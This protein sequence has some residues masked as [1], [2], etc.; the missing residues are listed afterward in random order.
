MVM[1]DMEM[2]C[3]LLVIGGGPG[4][5]GAALR[6]AELGLDVALVDSGP[7][8]GG[9]YLRSAC[10]PSK[11]L[12]D[13][14]RLL[15]QTAEAASLGVV[16]PPPKLDFSEVCLA[17]SG[18]IAVEG[19]KL[20]LR[21][22]KQGVLL[23]RGTA[24]F[25]EPRRVRLD[26]AEINRLSFD[27]AIIAVGSSPRLLPGA[28]IGGPVL[29]IPAL[30]AAGAFPPSITVVGGGYIGIELATILA[31]FGSR[32][33]LLEKQPRLLSKAD[34]DL[35]APLVDSLTRR[36]AAIRVDCQ[37]TEITSLDDGVT[38]HCR[39]GGED[40]QWRDGAVLA[41]IG[42]RPAADDL[43]L[44]R[45]LITTD[46]RGYII[47]NERQQTND[48]AIFAVGDIVGDHLL[49]HTALR[50]GRVAA[51]VAAGHNSAFDVRA[52]PKLVH[53][54]PQLAWCGLTEEEARNHGI[55]HQVQRL[56][57]P[58]CGDLDDKSDARFFAKLLTEPE[59]GRILGVGLVGEH[60]DGFIGEAALA[61]EMGGLAED[62]ALVLHPFPF[63]EGM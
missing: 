35:V 12:L 9:H 18:K 41:A 21:A 47:V 43:G 13:L 24:R 2:H 28:T 50:Q 19:E 27:Q 45:A 26:G 15:D 5:Y 37:V 29:D 6:A 30:W 20:A 23:L 22:K 31:A 55:P 11:Y 49:A 48:P 46:Q 4:G 16:F 59:S 52:V 7:N 1:G 8:P 32:V 10:L 3:Q 58:F 60:L 44:E 17:L 33:T 62:L 57:H 53:T 51:E 25:V 63:L 34:E 38:L 39:Q 36:L 54:R 61:V 56:S 14:I 40:V 42:R